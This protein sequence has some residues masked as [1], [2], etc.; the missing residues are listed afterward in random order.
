MKIVF[1]S[2][3]A[4]YRVCECVH[5]KSFASILHLLFTQS[6]MTDAITFDSCAH[7]LHMC[8]RS[9]VSLFIFEEKAMHVGNYYLSRN[10]FNINSIQ[11]IFFSLKIT[12]NSIMNMKL[13]NGK[14]EKPVLT[15]IDFFE[16]KKLEKIHYDFFVFVS[17]SS[18][19]FATRNSIFDSK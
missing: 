14:Y 5:Q 15:N 4:V 1:F 18:K 16:K 17:S 2:T 13:W 9:I 12:A 8:M 10:L 3:L 7:F 6:L 11:P 19:W